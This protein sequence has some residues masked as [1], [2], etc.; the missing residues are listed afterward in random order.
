MREEILTCDSCG[1]RVKWLYPIPR[2]IVEGNVINEYP[3]RNEICESCAR[4]LCDRFNSFR[5]IDFA[6]SYPAG[7]ET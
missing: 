4:I 1:R 7:E 6:S 3:G 5:L 2:L